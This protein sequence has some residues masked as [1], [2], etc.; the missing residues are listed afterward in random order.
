MEKPLWLKKREHQTADMNTQQQNLFI[1][2][3]LSWLEF[4]ERVLQCAHN[5]A[6]PPL[7]RLKFLAITASNLDEFFMVRVGGLQ[8]LS[9][10]NDRKKDPAG[11]RPSEQLN[12]I[13]D[14][15]KAMVLSQYHCFS[16]LSALLALSG[17]QR[18]HPNELL[19]E[20]GKHAEYVFDG[21]IAPVVSPMAVSSLSMAPLLVNRMLYAAVRLSSSSSNQSSGAK[22]SRAFAGH[23][24]AI[25][26][27]GKT[28]GRF[29]MVPS[30]G[31]YHY[32]LVEDLI[33]LF[34]GRF[35]PGE[36][37]VETGCFRVT[38]NADMSL[39]EDGASDLAA[40]MEAVVDA[41][42]RGDCVRLEIGTEITQTLA[43]DL[44]ALVGAPASAVYR[45]PGPLDL[46]AFMRFSEL[47]GYDKLKYKPWPSRTPPI[48][49]AGTSM[50]DIIAKRDILLF[51][52]YD[53]FEPVLR[54][55]Q[56]AAR[57]PKVV[58]I[59]QTL[60]RTSKKSP[61]V[62][63]LAEA[64]GAGKY[65]TAIVELKARF[66]EERNIE[67]AT[68]L[69]DAGVQVIYGVKGL[70]THAKVFIAVRREPSG[71]RRYLHFGTGNY[72]ELTASIYSDVS[73]MTCNEDLGADASA[74]FN[75]ITG[76][77]QPQSYRKID[78]APL[79]LKE[80]ALSLIEAETERS[81]QGQ[82]AFIFAKMNS[83]THP[84]IIEALYAASRAG[85][86]IQ[87]NIRG[88]CCLKPGVKGHSEN[89]QVK[90]IVGRFLE[91]ARIW[92][93]GNGGK[94]KLF[95]CTADWMQRNLDKRVELLTPV[96]D[97]DS[98]QRLMHILD[99][100]FRDSTNSWILSPDGEWNKVSDA[101]GAR[102]DRNCHA[103]FYDE[104][105][106][107]TDKAKSM[108]RTMFETHKPSKN[109]K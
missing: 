98:R 10:S 107:K 11:L 53:S 66:D 16:E 12:A 35:F 55:I 30:D 64:A 37:V 51:H 20:Q 50:F 42:K 79:G 32:V 58:A 28:L 80:R 76:N 97:P 73:Y 74:F 52:P 54:F 29:I 82:K 70:K 3:E 78:A 62:A 91:H 61:I 87:L 109:R 83:L 85:V 17:I 33:S 92:R 24:L 63:A 2:R 27:V 34:A 84:E 43:R 77:S 14:R 89:I 93:F 22:P 100:C 81:R 19:G 13:F 72:N 26:P 25:I 8:M 31:C 65:V 95:I 46:S 96:E 40:E 5:D 7:E 6:V 59:K 75:S 94:E 39:R 49:K 71:L 86:K 90:S 68:E 41:R 108:K 21:E 105:C 48:L 45:T 69:E 57:D 103:T 88:I 18:L 102:K 9:K 101:G 15:T 23:R 47:S 56:E 99:V 104:V 67:W 106:E 1:N 4:N 44:V 36:T 38:R 60:Y